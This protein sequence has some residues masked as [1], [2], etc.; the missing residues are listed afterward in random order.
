MRYYQQGGAAPQQDMQQQIIA[1][2][3]AAM[4]GDQQ[5][6]Q[7]INQIMEA[8]K[9]GDQQA[10]QLAQMIQ[11]I[12]Q[13]MQSQAVAA[14]WGAKLKYI[15]SLKYAKGGKACPTC[16]SEGGPAKKINSKVKVAY[17]DIDNKTYGNLPNED[18]AKSDVH[19]ATHSVSTN[20]DGSYK[21]SH[22]P[23]ASDS[24]MVDIKH[25]SPTLRKK[26]LVKN[27]CGGKAKKHYFGGWL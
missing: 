5:A 21:I 20:K 12:A 11:Q 13:Q 25:L 26:Y 15:K 19:S 22:K 8:A 9:A 14:K 23:T 16:M 24:L 4:Q 7:T 2:V 10:A 17:K 27:E 6:T 3:Q 1:L 18:K